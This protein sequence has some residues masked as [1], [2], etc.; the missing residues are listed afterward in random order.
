M[1]AGS[2]T[3]PSPWEL[4]R[5]I[6]NVEERA[7]EQSAAIASQSEQYGRMLAALSDI[8]EDIAG[9]KDSLQRIEN[10][11]WDSHEDRHTP[12]IAVPIQQ[13]PQSL[14]NGNGGG[15]NLKIMLG[16]MS[17]VSTLGAGLVEVIKL[18]LGAH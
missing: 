4:A 9:I 17:L 1:A 7:S 14:F 11:V 2:A 15:M 16:L 3:A 6:R 12:V 18:L 10:R 5:R 8:H 13:A